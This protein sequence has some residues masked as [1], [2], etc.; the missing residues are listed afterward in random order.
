[1]RRQGELALD[2]QVFNAMRRVMANQP[3]TFARSPE[4]GLAD[5]HVLFDPAGYRLRSR[6]K[7][8]AV[9]NRRSCAGTCAVRRQ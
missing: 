9:W 8:A 3:H 7:A 6:L 1:M 2:E 4:S 5:H